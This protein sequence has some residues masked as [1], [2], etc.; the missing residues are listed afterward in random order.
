MN[1]PGAKE[2]YSGKIKSTEFWMVFFYVKSW[3]YTVKPV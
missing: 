1:P 2:E 3:K